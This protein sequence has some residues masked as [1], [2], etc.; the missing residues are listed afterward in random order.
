MQTTGSIVMTSTAF[1]ILGA[2]MGLAIF[3]S[4]YGM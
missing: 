3:A 1:A 2:L 4:A